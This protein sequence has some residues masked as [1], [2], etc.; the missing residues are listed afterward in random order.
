MP[1][2][3][4][5]LRQALALTRVGVTP[6]RATLEFVQNRRPGFRTR[7]GRK[8]IPEVFDQLKALKLTKVLNRLQCAVGA[9]A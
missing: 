1:S 5:C 6:C 9:A 2:D 4:A 3:C 8:L 7:L